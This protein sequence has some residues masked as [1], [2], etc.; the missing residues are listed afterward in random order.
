MNASKA[1]IAILSS[2]LSFTA[3]AEYPDKPITLLSP[4]AVGGFSDILARSLAQK[5]TEQTG[6]SVVVDNKTGAA[7]RIGY[8]QGAKSAPDGY[9]YTI[10]DVTYMM[11]P[12]L[13]AS[14]TWNHADLVPVALFG[15]VPF[16]FAVQTTSPMTKLTDLVAAAKAKPG[17]VNY[18]SSGIG[19]VNQVVTTLFARNIGVTMTNI[20]Y[21]GAG[22]ALTGLLGGQID[23]LL[24][25]MPTAMGQLKG[26]KLR[27]LAVTSA[28]R[29][30]AAPDI[31]TSAEAGIPFVASNWAGLT[32]PRGTPKEATDWMQKAVSAA[33]A[34]PQIKESYLAQGAEPTDMNAEQFGKFMQSEMTRWGNV[35]KDAKIVAE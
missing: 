5:I 3:S 2:V 30:A 14:L 13:H 34:T 4:F 32:V 22:E 20:P 26:G 33:L 21:R 12:A 28:K 27:A 6:K 23:F 15:Q 17:A 35:I 25:A 31:P 11:M 29:S 19:S 7:G 10:T 16:V 1:L 24:T 8:S 18:G 9:T